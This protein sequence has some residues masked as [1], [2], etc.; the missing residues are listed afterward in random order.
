[1]PKHLLIPQGDFPPAGLGRR[2]A[3]MFYDFLLCTALLIVTSGAYKMIQMAI[4]GE[5]KM[6]A[7]TEAGALDGDPLLSTVLLFVLFGFFAKFWTH[8]GQTLGMQVWCIRVQNADGT[9]ISLWQALL[10]FVVSIA[11]LL[12]LGAGFIWALFDKRKRSWH[13]IYSD[14]QLVRIPKKAK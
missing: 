5:E 13:D 14:T 7:L 2:L 4:I 1:M 8:N 6:R 10:R 11:S 9:A 3:A 12:L